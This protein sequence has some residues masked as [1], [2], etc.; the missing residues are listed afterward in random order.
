MKTKMPP[1]VLV[2]ALLVGASLVGAL[3]IAS[4]LIGCLPG[5]C[6]IKTCVNGKCTCPLSTCAEG[7]EF[8]L[9]TN[10]CACRAGLFT[11]QGQCLT[12]P[13]AD[14]FCG[15][16]SGWNATGCTA[17]VCV[18]GQKL[19]QGTGD[20][21]DVAAVA[22]AIGVELHQ[23]E[24]IGCPAGQTLVTEGALAA[25]VPLAQ[26]CA[27]DEKFDGASCVKIKSCASG[28]VVDVTTGECV[29][30]GKSA[31]DSYRVD[32][33]AWADAN[34]GKDGAFGTSAFCG[35][36]ARRPWAFGVQEGQSA[37]LRVKVVIGFANAAV[38]AGAVKVEPSYEHA[39]SLAVPQGGV[40][41][42][43]NA[44]EEILGRLVSGGGTA[45]PKDLAFTVRC[46]VV[47]AS[48]PAA[49]PAV[50]GV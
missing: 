6:L 13:Q 16:G 24:T 3:P 27:P 28:S 14:R 38:S 4:L 37:M 35:A 33:R 36:F 2:G 11:V 21:K 5:V 42:V 31:S 48:K 41:G 40:V 32:T 45:E 30:Y 1:R 8:D 9:A 12:Q 19:D 17:K 50:G 49:V 10:A 29:V 23:G 7:A 15:K 22:S 20:C 43:Q 18:A 46:P 39:P 47:N 44:A 34:Y 26:S 25:C